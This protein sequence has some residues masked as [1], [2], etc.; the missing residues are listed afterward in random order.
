MIAIVVTLSKTS[1]PRYITSESFG[2]GKSLRS[3]S[4]GSDPSPKVTLKIASQKRILSH[5]S[6]MRKLREELLD[7]SRR[8]KWLLMRMRSI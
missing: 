1:Q 2:A 6:K 7:T 4:P 8:K 5:L 3:I